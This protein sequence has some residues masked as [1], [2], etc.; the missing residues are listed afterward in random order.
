MGSQFQIGH[1]C[2]R[3]H[4]NG[5]KIENNLI[6]LSVI[7][8]VNRIPRA[9]L[10][11]NYR[12]LLSQKKIADVPLVKATG[13]EE[14]AP[15]KPMKFEPGEA[16]RI[17]LRKG[18]D[19]VEVFN[20]HITKHQ[21]TAGNGGAIQLTV[22]C[23]HVSNK[24]T[25]NKRTR[26]HHHDA[27]QKGSANEKI[28]KVSDLDALR[29]LLKES[30]TQ[31]TLGVPKGFQE[32]FNHENLVQYDCTDW[33]FLVMRAEA[34]GLVTVVERDRINLIKPELQE[35]EKLKLK[36]GENLL[37]YESQYTETEVAPTI[38]FTNWEIDNQ[39]AIE[40]KKTTQKKQNDDGSVANV[41]SDIYLNHSGDIAVAES[42][43]WIDN[44][45]N[46]QGI[47]KKQGVAKLLGTV[48]VAPGDTVSVVSEDLV[49]DEK[50]F[51]SGIKHVVQNGVWTSEAQ[52]GLSTRLHAQEYGLTK[53]AA[54]A[55]LPETN[56]ML[57]GKVIG[58]KTSEGG[59]ELIEV[60]LA[61]ANNKAK[62]QTVYARLATLSAGENGG[63]V[64]RPYPNDEV[65]I[66][67]IQND[68]RFPVILGSFY[69]SK[70]KEPLSLEDAKQQETGFVIND[71]K[72]S[73]DEKNNKL[74]IASPDGQTVVLDDKEKQLSLIFNDQN[75]IE[76]NKEGIT[77]NA[78][79]IALKGSKEI[80]LSAPNITAKATTSV[81]IEGTQLELEGKVATTIKGQITQIN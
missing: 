8:A 13:F 79:K 50:I 73:I 10:K 19:F 69:N 51:V 33:D 47:A 59:H 55:M 42:K 60:E 21:L 28:D 46:R 54:T 75:S 45:K 36:H 65:V 15:E 57:Y 71:W 9:T 23:K 2:Y 53:N 43:S 58:Y 66:G 22:D 76:I 35:N 30:D 31:L 16:I 1:V 27:N 49:L 63:A 34:L 38:N 32:T 77:L 74:S 39:K 48:E 62:E 26:L 11:F 17:E 61:S 5:T 24:L 56:G 80:E 81:K 68:P 37:E 44:L 52:L 25:L 4:L 3:V 64:F 20:G 67:F 72:V 6:S 14:K 18:T 7:T 41:Q 70:N 40:E 78:A 12:D 29:G